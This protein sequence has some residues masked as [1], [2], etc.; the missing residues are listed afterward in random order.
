MPRPPKCRRVEFVPEIT[1]FKPA[2]VPLVNLEE[3]SLTIEELE[4]V[5]LKDLEALEQE[6][7]AEKMQVSR[8]TFH[9][10]LAAARRKIAEALVEGKAI[11]VEGGNYHHAGSFHGGK[12]CRNKAK[13]F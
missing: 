8:P 2:G 6:Q 7:C 12:R 4:A 13:N 3:I 11:K 1:Y 5:R 9:R 10:I